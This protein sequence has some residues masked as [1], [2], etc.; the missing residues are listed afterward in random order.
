M[1]NAML[2]FAALSI[3][4]SPLPALGFKTTPCHLRLAGRFFSPKY[5]YDMQVAV[6]LTVH[7]H[8]E[9]PPSLS[10]RMRCTSQDKSDC[11]L[12]DGTFNVD[13]ENHADGSRIG[14]R[15]RGFTMARR[16]S[17]PGEGVCALEAVTGYIRRRGCF[18]AIIGTF[19]CPPE[20]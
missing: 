13:L 15:T 16:G 19:V 11:F 18:G 3:V 12:A 5:D 2:T 10:G 17:S 7:G 6:R 4:L 8:G 20:G 9:A 1:K 14:L